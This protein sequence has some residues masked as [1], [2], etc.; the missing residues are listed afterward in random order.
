MIDDD[1]APSLDRP[2][3]R[4]KNVRFKDYYDIS[5]KVRRY[6]SMLMWSWLSN[7]SR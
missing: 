1:A 3:R 4:I 6:V 5:G 2:V 7:Q